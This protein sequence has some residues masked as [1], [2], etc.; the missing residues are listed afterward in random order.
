MVCTSVETLSSIISTLIKTAYAG[1]FIKEYTMCTLAG[2][3]F[4]YALLVIIISCILMLIAI[5]RIRS[6]EGRKKAVS[7]CE[8]HLTA[9][10]IVYG[11]LFFMYLRSP[12]EESAE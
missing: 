5:L 11:I 7:T 3:N 1:S 8:S 9:V 6:A 2:L 10:T 4:S 12:T